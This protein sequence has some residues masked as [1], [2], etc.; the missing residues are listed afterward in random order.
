MLG[1]SH[2]ISGDVGLENGFAVLMLFMLSTRRARSQIKLW[3]LRLYT[4]C[5]CSISKQFDAGFQR[6]VDHYS[7]DAFCYLL[8]GKVENLTNLQHSEVRRLTVIE[9]FI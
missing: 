4:G 2:V 6:V 5:V 3:F 1:L 8:G 7:E 9:P